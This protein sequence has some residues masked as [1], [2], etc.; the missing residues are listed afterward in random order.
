[1]YL[2]I[3]PIYV[4]TQQVTIIRS[5]RSSDRNLQIIIHIRLLS[6]LGIRGAPSPW[7]VIVFMTW[8]LVRETLRIT[9][10]EKMEETRQ[11]EC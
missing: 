1:M 4:L 7:S 3:P 9:S 11:M 8:Y 5:L 6:R 10:P 2:F